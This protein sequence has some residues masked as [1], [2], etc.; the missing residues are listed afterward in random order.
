M[1]V[2]LLIASLL[3]TACAP[4][5][6]FVHQSESMCADGQV[7]WCSTTLSHSDCACLTSADA[8]R[9]YREFFGAQEQMRRSSRV[10]D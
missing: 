3:V 8:K 6:E 1:R 7:Q 9:T 5:A 2:L 4:S 10:R